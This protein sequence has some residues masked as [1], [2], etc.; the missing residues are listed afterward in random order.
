MTR[1]IDVEVSRGG[2]VKMEF[3]GFLGRVLEV[4]V[5]QNALGNWVLGLPVT[6]T[7]VTIRIESELPRKT[8]GKAEGAL[9]HDG[10]WKRSEFPSCQVL[11][12]TGDQGIS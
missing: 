8:G 1:R 10:Q 3:S 6:I 11:F 7:P 2:R 4:E 5:L 9:Y 12:R